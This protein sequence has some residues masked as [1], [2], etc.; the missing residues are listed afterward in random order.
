MEDVKE[1]VKDLDNPVEIKTVNGKT[2]F[3]LSKPLN[4]LLSVQ[5]KKGKD[6]LMEHLDED[7]RKLWS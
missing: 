5:E 1:A 6:P 7:V 3:R 4:T 2:S